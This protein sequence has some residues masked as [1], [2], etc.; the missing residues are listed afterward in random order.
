MA[1]MRG[2]FISSKINVV[3][4]DRFTFLSANIVV[5][6]EKSKAN[7]VVIEKSIIF[8][9]TMIASRIDSLIPFQRYQR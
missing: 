1:E 5:G 3:T 9:Q 6:G 8:E 4:L 7:V 2:D